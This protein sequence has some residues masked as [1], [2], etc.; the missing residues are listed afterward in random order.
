MQALPGEKPPTS[1][2]GPAPELRRVYAGWFEGLLVRALKPRMTPEL[3]AE[4]R[5][6][7][8][9]LE[10]PLAE[11]YPAGVRLEVIRLL[12][13]HLYPDQSDEQAWYELG[14]AALDGFLRTIVGRAFAVLFRLLGPR[15]VMKRAS[16]AFGAV[17]NYTSAETIERA[18][19]RWEVRLENTDLPPAYYRGMVLG[20]LEFCQLK[21]L[22]VQLVSHIGSQVVLRC[23]WAPP[24][25]RQ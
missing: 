16:A 11:H 22:Q 20:A 10:R 3:I 5:T 14:R 21:D 7:G 17:T 25:T 18:P 15:A 6:A 8:L 13:E 1:V 12:R 24:Q 9:D 4:L 23:A 19:F 2:I